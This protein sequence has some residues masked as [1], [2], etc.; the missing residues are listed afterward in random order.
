MGALP[1]SGNNHALPWKP[2]ADEFTEWT[3]A[4]LL[5]LAIDNALPLHEVAPWSEDQPL[6]AY[7]IPQWLRIQFTGLAF[8][9]GLIPSRKNSASQNSTATLDCRSD[10]PISQ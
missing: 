10:Y 4:L 9:D 8:G 1:I 2:G 3:L 6:K 5:A 7:L